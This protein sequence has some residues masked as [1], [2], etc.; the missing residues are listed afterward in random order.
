MGSLRS[1][2][3]KWMQ[4]GTSAGALTEMIVI[5]APQ[6]VPDGSGGETVTWR[7]VASA[8]AGVQVVRATEAETHG[9]L[10]QVSVVLFTVWRDAAVGMDGTYRIDW[11]GRKYNVREVR[12]GPSRGLTVEIVGETGAGV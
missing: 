12:F 9:G 4:N 11:D 3:P 7:Q 10:R 8:F 2:L 1:D 6:T 5:H